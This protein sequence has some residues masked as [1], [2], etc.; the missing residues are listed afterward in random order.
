MT[1]KEHKRRSNIDWNIVFA[2]VWWGLCIALVL[3]AIALEA[4]CWIRYGSV[5][6]DQVPNWVWW[7][8]WRGR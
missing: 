6:S 5:P 7:F 3:S 1:H 4:Y 8:M 2:C